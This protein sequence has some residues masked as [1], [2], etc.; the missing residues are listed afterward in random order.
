MTKYAPY[1]AIARPITVIT[2][3]EDKELYMLPSKEGVSAVFIT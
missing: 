1:A 2:L 3:W